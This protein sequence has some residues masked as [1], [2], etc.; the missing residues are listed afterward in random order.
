LLGRSKTVNLHTARSILSEAPQIPTLRHFPI[1]NLTPGVGR[2]PRRSAHTLVHP[3]LAPQS[4]DSYLAVWPL[5]LTAVDRRARLL[6]YQSSLRLK[7]CNP[8]SWWGRPAIRTPQTCM[9]AC[10]SSWSR[11][12]LNC[13]PCASPKVPHFALPAVPVPVSPISAATCCP[14]EA[15]RSPCIVDLPLGPESS[16]KGCRLS[17]APHMGGWCRGIQGQSGGL[18]RLMLEVGLGRSGEEEVG[19]GRSTAKCERPYIH[20]IPARLLFAIPCCIKQLGDNRSQPAQTR[21]WQH[22]HSRR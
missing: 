14:V 1:Q 15:Q 4:I 5:H 22:C 2:L 10:G 20:D 6:F 19:R 18:G 13:R 7:T 12:H 8:T 11:K 21:I 9:H 17:W 3:N 16:V